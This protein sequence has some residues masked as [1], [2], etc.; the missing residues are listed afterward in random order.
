MLKIG[1]SEMAMSPPGGAFALRRWAD[2]ADR[3][4]NVGLI[5]APG[6]DAMTRGPGPNQPPTGK[7]RRNADVL[8]Q[9]PVPC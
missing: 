5:R 3:M 6:P 7:N 2:F 8:P 1:M 4:V 9:N